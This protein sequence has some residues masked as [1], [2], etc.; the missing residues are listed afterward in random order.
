MQAESV[1]REVEERAGRS[2]L[3]PSLR[4]LGRFLC[5]VCNQCQVISRLGVSV[6]P[7]LHQSS[8]SA[9]RR[10]SY[11]LSLLESYCYNCNKQLCR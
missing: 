10:C 3:S 9:E 4:P 6:L 5:P 8:P 7:P 1:L 2:P 11:H